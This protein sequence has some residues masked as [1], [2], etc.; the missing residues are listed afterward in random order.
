LTEFGLVLPQKP[1]L[2]RQHLNDVLEDATTGQTGSRQAR[3]VVSEHNVYHMRR[4]EPCRA[5]RIWGRI[6]VFMMFPSDPDMTGS[7]TVAESTEEKRSLAGSD[8]DEARRRRIICPTPA[9]ALG[10]S[11]FRQNDLAS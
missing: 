9:S 8:W 11:V 7:V 3:I 1:T 10:S 4:M 6:F 5:V 2:L